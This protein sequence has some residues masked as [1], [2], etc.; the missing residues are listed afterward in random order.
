MHGGVAGLGRAWL[1]LRLHVVL[2]CC[3]GQQPKLVV[4]I[5]SKPRQV[6]VQA[7]VAEYCRVVPVVAVAAAA[8]AAVVG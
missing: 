3:W 7:C 6:V 5:A 2:S 8:A 4:G 1:G